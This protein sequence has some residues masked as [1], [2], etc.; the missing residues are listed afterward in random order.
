[1]A[2]FDIFVSHSHF[3][4]DFCIRLIQALYKRIPEANIFFDKDSIHVGDDWFDTISV[5][6][7]KR[8][9]FIVIMTPHSVVAPFVK[10]ET[11]LALYQATRHPDSRWIMPIIYGNH[12]NPSTL[13]EV[14]ALRHYV[15]CTDDEESGFDSLAANIRE[16]ATNQRHQRFLPPPVRD[17]STVSAAEQTLKSAVDI[18]DMFKKEQWKYVVHFGTPLLTKPG[19]KDNAE[20][21]AQVGYACLQV[22]TLT[23]EGTLEDALKYL[24]IA[25]RLIPQRPDFLTWQ[26]QGY[27]KHGDVDE[28]LNAWQTALTYIR[29]YQRKIELFA[30]MFEAMRSAN[31]LSLARDYADIAVSLL[32]VTEVDRGFRYGWRYWALQCESIDYYERAIEALDHVLQSEPE[33]SSLVEKRSEL[34]EKTKPGQ[35]P[36]EEQTELEKKNEPPDEKRDLRA[37]ALAILSDV[38]A[39]MK[40]EGKY[41]DFPSVNARLQDR[42]VRYRDL[43]FSQLSDFLTFAERNGVVQLNREYWLVCLP[44]EQFDSPKKPLPP[45]SYPSTSDNIDSTTLTTKDQG[46]KAIPP[47]A[48]K[49]ALRFIDITVKSLPYVTVSSL[50]SRMK[51]AHYSDNIVTDLLNTGV[52]Q[53]YPVGPIFDNKGEQQ[54]PTAVRFDYNLPEISRLYDDHPS[55]WTQLGPEQRTMIVGMLDDL[56]KESPTWNNLRTFLEGATR[57]VDWDIALASAADMRVIRLENHTVDH[58]E[59]HKPF[60]LRIL[61]LERHHPDVVQLLRENATEPAKKKR[62]LFGWFSGN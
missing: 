17:A 14:L 4:T 44:N 31:Q 6:V 2:Q 18:D 48:D 13:S 24:A 23:G 58:K 1:M 30:E 33:D 19:Y 47:K 15:D 59:N 57:E 16:T 29:S 37:E 12:V 51:S 25:H 45:K 26:A 46:A 38:L 61:S 60:T 8:P 34:K 9:I 35:P 62:G 32:A 54:F 11:N 49:E 55:C 22:Y 39:Q 3:D 41:R 28:A 36:D 56:A 40:S 52:L 10:L 7:V 53:Q 20:L 42:N 43:S 5:E 21:N 27:I 50:R